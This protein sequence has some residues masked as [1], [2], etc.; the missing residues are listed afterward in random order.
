MPDSSRRILCA[1]CNAEISDLAGACPVC[2]GE[3]RL[4]GRYRLEVTVGL[5][6]SGTT[7]RATDEAD[8]RGPRTV[9]V[10]EV[11][12]RAAVAD[13]VGRRIEREARV[14]R[15]LHHAE[16]PEYIDAFEAGQGKQRAF[17]LVQDFVEGPNLAEE[18]ARRRYTEDE[19][20]DLLDEV[21]G[22]LA[23]LHRLSPPVIHRDVK[24]KN[25]VRRASDGR[26]VLIDFGAVRDVV[27]DPVTGG[28]TVAGTYGYMAPEQ[29]RGDAWPASDVY[30]VG[31]LAVTLLS[32]RDPI[33]LVGPDHQLDWKR[34]VTARPEM[35]AWLDEMLAPDH[36]KRPAN[37]TAAREALHVARGA[38]A[39]PRPMQPALAQTQAAVVRPPPIA[40]HPVRVDREMRRRLRAR[41]KGAAVALAILGGFIGAHFWYLGRY[42][43]G[44]LSLVFCFTGLPFLVSMADG[45]R[46]A[47]M[48]QRTFDA[49]F[50]PGIAE[51]EQ[52]DIGSTTDQIRGLYALYRDGAISEAE[53]EREKAR[54]LGQRTGLATLFGP[55]GLDG[56]GRSIERELDRHMANVAQIAELP[57]KLLNEALDLADQRRTHRHRRPWGPRQNLT[58]QR[59][60]RPGAEEDGR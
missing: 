45:I 34:F 46:L 42:V 53:Y 28:S 8:P 31:V 57:Q 6:A 60:R 27:Q 3:T 7:F 22:I 43:V 56:V 9:A 16:I 15:Q 59:R 49:E 58:R 23:Y 55:H 4:R 47:F 32:R 12:L 50:N 44:L 13:E 39:P 18:M 54:V 19:V 5:G 24:P 33:D 40:H 37:A 25:L 21:L 26:L 20:L 36:R 48:S 29:F 51:L 17:Y 41:S 38:A 14:L 30:A 10:K 1:A 11:P 52:G 2:G 35:I